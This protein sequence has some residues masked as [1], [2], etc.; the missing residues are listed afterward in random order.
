M[1]IS[2]FPVN[3]WWP[4]LMYSEIHQCSPW[5]HVSQGRKHRGR[6]TP[7]TRR[8]STMDDFDSWVPHQL[9]Q[10]FLDVHCSFRL[11]HLTFLPSFCP[12]PG[13]DL[14][15]ILNALLVLTPLSFSIHRCFLKK[16]SYISNPILASRGTTHPI[17]SWHSSQ[18]WLDYNQ[19]L[20]LGLWTSRGL[21]LASSWISFL[22]A[23]SAMATQ[24]SWSFLDP[25]VRFAC[26]CTCLP[27]WNAFA[28]DY[29]FW[30][31]FS[32]RSVTF[33]PLTLLYFFFI[34]FNHHFTHYI[35]IL[36]ICL[37]VLPS[38]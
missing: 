23:G 16:I 17:V 9:C 38:L 8:T 29:I 1:A 26:L 4:Q 31:L 5:G 24:V 30:S 37:L 11:F 19:T 32:F 12:W 3:D 15:C 2:D 20:H 33:Y 34:A 35:F 28:P 36:F 25:L 10:I 13:S 14:P 6:P 27:I 18:K 21:A 22:F 7:G